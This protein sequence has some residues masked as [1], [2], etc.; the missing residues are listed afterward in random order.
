VIDPKDLAEL[1]AR[2]RPTDQRDVVV[3]SLQ[4]NGAARSKPDGDGDS[5]AIIE[6]LAAAADLGVVAAE[7]RNG[8]ISDL[9]WDE[10][11]HGAP[12]PTLDELRDG[13]GDGQGARELCAVIFI[14]QRLRYDFKF[15]E[16]QSFLRDSASH[17]G[18]DAMV[19]ALAAFAELGLR[20]ERAGGMVK[21]ALRMPDAD[22]VCRS[23]ILHG[24][25]FHID[26]EDQAR[27]IIKLADK[28]VELGEEDANLY[29]WRAYALRRD[30]R[31]G[32]ALKSID[33]AI[34][35]LPAN[36][37]N[38]H[39]DYVRERELI[40]TMIMYR[41]QTDDYVNAKVSQAM[42]EID[43]RAVQARDTIS[44]SLASLV[45]VLGL[46]IAII[47]FLAG[48]TFTAFQDLSTWARIG[49]LVALLAGALAFFLVLRLVVVNPGL[50]SALRRR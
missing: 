5:W 11:S 38:V 2:T 30:G 32:Q 33:E 26:L 3:R 25:W 48:T 24:L 20:T 10:R 43:A 44:G 15:A 21:G 1:L 40:V 6:T 50:R 8:A 29:Y 46:F 14:A 27:R 9:A 34:R 18:D 7:V 41:Q 28:M 42:E 13:G 45:E 37:N 39:Q 4:R 19:R 35:R 31:Y 22:S 17:Y 23:T 47:A 49:T 16:L 12:M 36:E